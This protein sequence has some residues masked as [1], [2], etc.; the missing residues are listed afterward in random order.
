MRWAAYLVGARRRQR[1]KQKPGVGTDECLRTCRRAA[2]AAAITRLSPQERARAPAEREKRKE[3]K[4]AGNGRS[5]RTQEREKRLGGLHGGSSGPVQ[6]PSNYGPTAAN[7]LSHWCSGPARQWVHP[8]PNANRAGASEWRGRGAATAGA[9]G[10][11]QPVAGAC[12]AMVARALCLVARGRKKT[13]E[14]PLWTLRFFVDPNSGEEKWLDKKKDLKFFLFF[15]YNKVLFV[16]S[17]YLEFYQIR[18]KVTLW[19]A[20]SYQPLTLIHGF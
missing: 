5:Q 9:S 18:P 17:E 10:P 14:A 1:A 15:F 13:T 6:Q 8:L 11:V 12:A 19:L 20:L 4:D 16:K 7:Q 3:S 2:A